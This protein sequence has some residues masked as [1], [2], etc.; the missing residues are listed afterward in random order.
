MGAIRLMLA[1]GV[2]LGHT[3]DQIMPAVHSHAD[4]RLTAGIIGGYSVLWFYV[5]SGFLMSTVLDTK[6]SADAKG[7][8]AFFRSRALRIFPLWIAIFFFCAIVVPYGGRSWIV[9]HGLLDIVRA[10]CLVGQDWRLIFSVYPDRD[11]LI[12]APGSEVSWTL[13]A[14]LT[15]YLLAPLL[16]RSTRWS[17][18]LFLGSAIWRCG[19]WWLAESDTTLTVTWN[20]FFFPSTLCFFLLGHLARKA[21]PRLP[22]IAGYGLLVLSL[23]S[24]MQLTMAPYPID[25]SW[26]YLATILFATSLPT[27]F[28]TTKDNPVS[29]FLGDLT[30]PLYLVGNICLLSLFAAW[31]GPVSGLG[32][33]LLRVAA[34]IPGETTRGYVVVALVTVFA[35]AVT[36]VV[37]FAVERPAIAVFRRIFDAAEALFRARRDRGVVRHPNVSS[38]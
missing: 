19:V 16:L 24:S 4:F 37:H 31:S 3:N 9:Q 25:N 12:F 18:V 27:L 30:Y 23:G 11:W 5:I 15:F 35:L 8:L 13:G 22:P 36:I 17:V 6:Y 38:P 26:F 29:N 33:L 2:L 21:M 32:R 7:T 1:F 28:A 34:A 20:Y 10:L 14:E